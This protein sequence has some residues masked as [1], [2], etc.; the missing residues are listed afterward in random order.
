MNI[1]QDRTTNERVIEL[2]MSPAEVEQAIVDWAMRDPKL[3]PS[4]DGDGR[5]SA[6][7][8]LTGNRAA[9]VTITIDLAAKS[10]VDV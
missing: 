8:H 1:T 7:I 6:S 5:V 2:I 4:L 9:K 3:S 10:V